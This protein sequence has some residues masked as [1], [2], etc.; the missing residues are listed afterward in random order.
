MNNPKDLETIK[1]IQKLVIISLFT[2]DEFMN[3]FVLK[4]GNA[5][6]IIYGL[7]DRASIDI[8]I[9]MANDFDPDQL[10]KIRN[11]L[12]KALVTTFEDHSF[13]VFDVTLIEKP[14]TPNP[15]TKDFWGGYLLEFKVIEKEKAQSLSHELKRKQALAIGPGN[16]TKFKV[17]ISKF[18]Y[19]EPKEEK[20][21]D[22]YTIYVYSPLMVVYEKLRA[23]CQQL[24]T[25]TEKIKQ[26]PRPR[27]RDFFDIHR[28]ITALS[29]GNRLLEP[30][31]IGILKAIFAAKNVPIIL[32]SEIVTQK[33][34][35][36][37]NFDSVKAAVKNKS[38]PQDFD[39]Y[40]DYVVELV[41]KIKASG[42]K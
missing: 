6:D 3:V 29:L 11:K 1:F 17:D 39:F 25:Y 4:G 41:H 27:A 33:E 22:G 8:D 35:H 23:I 24:P 7:S 40:F 10:E 13:H 37:V 19:C 28:I 38:E 15:A 21:L 18:E 14:N 2:D 34:F 26:K 20:D 31:N 42:V 16:S 12:E 5:I 30:A 36:A 9:S 32:L